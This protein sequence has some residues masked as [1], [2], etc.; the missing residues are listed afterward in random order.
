[1]DNLLLHKMLGCI[2]GRNEPFSIQVAGI[3]M[4]PVIANGQ[5]VCFQK[6]ESYKAGDNILFLYKND[7]LIVHRLLRIEGGIYYCK[8]DN[9]FRIE[10]V[11]PERILGVA[12][13]EEDANN[14]PEFIRDSWEIGQLFHRLKYDKAAVL[15]TDEYREYKLKYLQS[16]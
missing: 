16:L 9:A 7:E 8:G 14:T 12:L 11:R 10:D 4:L 13:L 1:M 3:S 6:K 5:T 2:A 15:L